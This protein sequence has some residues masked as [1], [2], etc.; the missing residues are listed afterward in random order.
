MSPK[1][2]LRI[3]GSTEYVDF[4]EWGIQRLRAKVDT[5]AR[6]SALHVENL[7]ELGGSRVRF[8]VRLHRSDR[9]ARVTV[10]ARVSR[11]GQV[12]HSSGVAE[13]RLFVKTRIALGGQALLI[14]LGLVDRG[15]LIYRMLLGRAA[16]ERRFLVDVSRRY[17]LGAVL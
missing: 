10:V 5:G 13:D 12:R 9:Q 11:R 14:E 15:K 16:L 3:V 8:D 7:R 1:Q 4:P 2:S 6:T 17:A